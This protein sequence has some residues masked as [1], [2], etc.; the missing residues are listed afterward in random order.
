MIFVGSDHAGFELKN[1]LLEFLKS[2]KLKTEDCGTTSAESCDYPVY[3]KIVSENV[4]KTPGAFGLLICGS[5][6]G[7]SIAANKINGIRAAVAGDPKSAALAREH[8]N[9]QILCLGARILSLEMAKKCLE[10]FLEAKFDTS[11][12]RHQRR[13]DLI[14][15]MEQE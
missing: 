13:I 2:K 11:N 1:Q 3:A 12:S 9:A 10:A 4:L 7:M 5:G 8:N 6:I 15:K 14:A